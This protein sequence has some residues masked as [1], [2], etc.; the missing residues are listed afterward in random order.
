MPEFMGED[1]I[2]S[3]TSLLIRPVDARNAMAPADDHVN[4]LGKA[5]FD[6][7]TDD[8]DCHTA[9]GAKGNHDVLSY[10]LP[11][12]QTF[13]RGVLAVLGSMPAS[14]DQCRSLKLLLDGNTLLDVAASDRHG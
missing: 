8:V 9:F 2:I 4:V 6:P 12:S 3:S 11:L 13:S 1:V 10:E 14:V 7:R 5:A